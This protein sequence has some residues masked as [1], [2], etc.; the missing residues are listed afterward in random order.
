MAKFIYVYDKTT[1]KKQQHQV[2]EWWLDHPVLG[3]NL[4]R[5]PRQKAADTKKAPAAGATEKE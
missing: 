5:T 4:S 2:P 3:A 1:G